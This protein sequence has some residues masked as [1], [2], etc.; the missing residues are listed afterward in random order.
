M[1]ELSKID[2]AS[3]PE[4]KRYL[5]D[6]VVQ[7]R[8]A[9][10]AGEIVSPEGPNRYRPGDALLT[11]STGNLWCV[12]RDRFDLKYQSVPPLAHGRDGAYRNRPLPVLAKQMH[13]SFSIER[14][15][16]GDKLRGSESDWLLQYAPGDYGIVDQARFAQV[17]RCLD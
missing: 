11:G 17:Y 3:D 4:A 9:L 7:V 13:E 8:F 15:S 6:E 16:G 2:L 12:S 14:S 5:K 1:L 10:D